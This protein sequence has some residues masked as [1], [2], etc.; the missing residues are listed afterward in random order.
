MCKMGCYPLPREK[1]A[2]GCVNANQYLVE[3]QTEEGADKR[4]I[5]ICR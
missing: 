5:D 3:Q 1:E 2:D 4:R